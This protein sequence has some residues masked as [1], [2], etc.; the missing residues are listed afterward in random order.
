MA[1]NRQT[2]AS[3]EAVLDAT[4]RLYKLGHNTTLSGN[5]SIRLPGNRMLITPSGLDK[6]RISADELSLVD[7]NS[8]EQ[9]SIEGPKPSS[10]FRVH[11]YL[12]I[13]PC[14]MCKQLSIRMAYSL[15][16]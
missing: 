12:S 6:G 1:A 4:R 8:K 14:Q 5:I 16:Q 11:T 15:L 9:K 13:W 3:A 10:E 7:I 2:Q